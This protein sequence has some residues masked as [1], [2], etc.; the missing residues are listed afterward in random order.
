M[1]NPLDKG[2]GPV[3]VSVSWVL[4]TIAVILIAMRFYVRVNVLHALGADDW[5]MLLAGACLSAVC[6]RSAS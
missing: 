1:A 2:R 6:D 3:I 4:T 5:V